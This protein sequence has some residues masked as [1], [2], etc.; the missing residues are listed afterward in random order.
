MLSINDFKGKWVQVTKFY[1]LIKLNEL[2]LGNNILKTF[3][4]AKHNFC[5]HFRLGN[6][7]FEGTSGC[8]INFWGNFQLQIQLWR[9][10]RWQNATFVGIS[11]C[12][13]QFLWAFPVAKHNFCHSERK[14]NFDS[15]FSS[16]TQWIAVF[17][18]LLVQIL[19]GY[20]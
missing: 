2:Y 9:H 7:I 5:R 3:P 16:E 14:A 6:T 20:I 1:N 12:E 19:L 11:G 15:Y 4:V 10:F 17:L 8:K 18:K 13:T